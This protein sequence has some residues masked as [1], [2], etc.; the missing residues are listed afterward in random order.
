M[1]KMEEKE[2]YELEMTDDDD[3]LSYPKLTL[4]VDDITPKSQNSYEMHCR[5]ACNGC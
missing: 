1:H 2:D 5:R 3:D 4:N